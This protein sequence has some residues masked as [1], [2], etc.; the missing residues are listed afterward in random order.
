MVWIRNHNGGHWPPIWT[1]FLFLIPAIV[2]AIYR[3]E[4]SPSGF[5]AAVM[6]I[7]YTF[8]AFN[9]QAFCN[10]YYFVIGAA[11]WSVAAMWPQSGAANS[12][13]QESGGEQ[14]LLPNL[15]SE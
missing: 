6:I 12:T 4:R 5:A 9:K 1:P 13:R 15:C 2:I 14:G 8:F 10:Y 11:L 7:T 3:C